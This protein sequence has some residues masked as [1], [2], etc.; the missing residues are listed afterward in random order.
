M[1]I[2]HASLHTIQHSCEQAQYQGRTPPGEMTNTSPGTVTCALVTKRPSMPAAFC[3]S[4][5]AAD[6]QCLSTIPV[7]LHLQKTNTVSK[8]VSC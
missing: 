7:L 3:N 8:N 6:T 4:G 2:H 1:F 5:E